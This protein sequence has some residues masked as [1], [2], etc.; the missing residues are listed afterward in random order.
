MW[1][2]TASTCSPIGAV[3]VRPITRCAARNVGVSFTGPPNSRKSRNVYEGASAAGRSVSEPMAT[4]ARRVST[5][6]RADTSIRSWNFV[7]VKWWVRLSF[8]S[9]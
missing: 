3:E 5:S 4:P 9:R 7:I 6:E 2:P 8:Q 1:A